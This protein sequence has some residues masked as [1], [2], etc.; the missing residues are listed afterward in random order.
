[1]IVSSDKARPFSP[2]LPV[3]PSNREGHEKVA[4]LSEPFLSRHLELANQHVETWKQIDPRQNSLLR[5]KLMRASREAAREIEKQTREIRIANR[6][7]DNVIGTELRVVKMWGEKINELVETDYAIF[8]REWEEVQGKKK[9]AIFVRATSA[10]LLRMIEHRG[11]G[12]AHGARNL[13]RR[14]GGIGK[15]LEGFYTELTRKLREDWKEKL[16]IEAQ[17]LDKQEAAQRRR[18]LQSAGDLVPPHSPVQPSLA[19]S[20]VPIAFPFKM[21]TPKLPQKKVNLSEYL[22][23]ARLTDKQH[24][25]ASWR[26]EYGL[27]V[28]EIAR[29]LGITRRTVDEHIAAATRKMEE[30]RARTKHLKGKAKSGIR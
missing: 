14:R 23:G 13:H 3:T 27:P 2:G 29:R 25:C 24:Q 1:L 19:S 20:F 15:S 12:K 8:C 30:A 18:G 10:H 6:L 28:A 9:T 7:I 17:E 16:D 22:E 4:M 26:L 21:P 5:K 11:N